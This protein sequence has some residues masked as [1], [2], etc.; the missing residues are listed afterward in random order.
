[1][2]KQKQ[3]T[4]GASYT[5]VPG[6]KLNAETGKLGTELTTLGLQSICHSNLN[7]IFRL[8]REGLAPFFFSLQISS[9]LALLLR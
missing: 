3:A 7:D 4:I 2:Q 1:M 5:I 8:L 6:V 9:Q